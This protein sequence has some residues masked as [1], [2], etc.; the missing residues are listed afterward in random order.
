MMTGEVFNRR[1]TIRLI[2][3]GP[4]GQQE[5]F[6]TVVDTGFTGYLSLP[7]GEVLALGLPFVSYYDAQVAT[8]AV[9]RLTVHEATISWHGRLR[10]I[11]VIATGVEALL[12][13]SLIYGSRLLLEGRDG[14]DLVLDEL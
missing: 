5:E 9:V 11:F 6:E 13:M 14:G 7:P 2:I 12:G 10:T 4:S 3:H 1:P 8:G